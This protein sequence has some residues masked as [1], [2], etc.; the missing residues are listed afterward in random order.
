M[1]ETFKKAWQ[2]KEIRTKLLFTLMIIAIYRIGCSIPVPGIDAS[3]IASNVAG[4]DFLSLFN[5]LTGG[6]FEQFA[7]FAMG[8]S[9]NIN[10][11][12]IIQ[13][14]TMVIPSLERLSK[15]GEEGRKKIA[16]ITR[17]ATLALSL[18]MAVGFTLGMRGALV[19]NNFFSYF[20][21]VLT[22]AAGSMLT[23][24]LGELIT[25]NGIGNGI[26]MLIFVGII[27]SIVPSVISIA[28]NVFSGSMA[29]WWIFILLALVVAI[30]AAII[31]MDKG[32]RKIQV[33][34][35]KKVVGRKVYGGQSTHI[36]MKLNP[37]G[38]M[39][40]I[41]AIS[42]VSLPSLIASWFPTSG[43]ATFVGKYLGQQS[44]V[45]II[46]YCLLIVFFAF[47][48]TTM[49]FNTY[50]VSK[51]LKENGGFVLGIRPGKPTADYLS[52]I[53][54]RLTLAGSIFLAF[55]AILPI[56]LGIIVPQLSNMAIGGSSI[57]IL[58]NVALETTNQLESMML[59]R[60]YKGFLKA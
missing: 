33:N 42:I 17:Y 40:I 1:F 3:V 29:W 34:Y 30:F 47:F 60:H 36:P 24:W 26:S 15:E 59:M 55:I 49:S 28:N 16:Q 56:I 45:Y 48:Y 7:I 39:P 35:A 54:N 37:S 51:N 57:I 23:M 6:A 21:I 41:F 38:V 25:E 52:R 18:L 53:L 10:A 8:I 32:E 46:V 2:I 9:P 5:V 11:S 4:S 43:F 13:L 22:L 12:I 58:V 50:E 19:D 31:F 14:L 27:S 20:F 44:V